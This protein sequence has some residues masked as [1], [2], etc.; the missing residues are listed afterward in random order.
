MFVKIASEGA[1]SLLE[2]DDYKKLSVR[3]AVGTPLSSVDATLEA[4]DAGKL[5]SQPAGHAALSVKWLRALQDDEAGRQAF[6]AM[7]EH[8]AQ[9]GWVIEGGS[10]LMAHLHRAD[11]DATLS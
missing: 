3:V 2:K 4:A 7:V 5:L 1:I 9:K 6:D 10:M 8:A 11:D